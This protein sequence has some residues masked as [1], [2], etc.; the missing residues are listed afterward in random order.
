MVLIV[1]LRERSEGNIKF[2][3]IMRIIDIIFARVDVDNFSKHLK[4]T[5]K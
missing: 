5:E 2:I 4:E 3:N 1:R